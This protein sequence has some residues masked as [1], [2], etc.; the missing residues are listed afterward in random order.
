M[1]MAR[2]R[3]LLRTSTFRLALIYMALF[4]G[5]V[6]LLLGFIYFTT[7]GYV[8][9]QTDEAIFAEISSLAERYRE[10]GLDGL[11]GSAANPGARS[12]AASFVNAGCPCRTQASITPPGT[13][14]PDEGT[15]ANPR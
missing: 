7:D 8:S 3:L 14:G 12:P 10:R 15:S 13:I 5:S 4:G 2:L 9:R 6:L 1:T 11:P